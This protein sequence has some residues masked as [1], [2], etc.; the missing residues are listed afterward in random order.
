MTILYIWMILL[1]FCSMLNVK[2]IEF[3]NLFRKKVHDIP[4]FHRNI[5][6]C[7]KLHCGD[8]VGMRHKC[9]SLNIW[10]NNNFK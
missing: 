2:N 1:D 9:G 3:R 4:C 8:M 10:E 6:S 7:N 5:D